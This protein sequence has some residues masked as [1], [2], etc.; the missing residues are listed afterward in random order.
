MVRK[1][2]VPSYILE[3]IKRDGIMEAKEDS[4]T[5]GIL[6]GLDVDGITTHLKRYPLF[7]K[8]GDG[9]SEDSRKIKENIPMV[10]NI[11][12]MVFLESKKLAN[13]GKKPSLSLYH[14]HPDDDGWSKEDLNAIKSDDI[15]A[16]IKMYGVGRST[17]SY[18]LYLVRRNNFLAV[19]D[20]A[21][22]IPIL[23]V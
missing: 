4:E 3:E 12:K 13:E 9:S 2:L 15:Y 6:L 20:R 1:L 22:R 18:I 10:M 8:K 21:K 17:T 19:D 5:T 16:G 7:P 23:R 14:S 11:S